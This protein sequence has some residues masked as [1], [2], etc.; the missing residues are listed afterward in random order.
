VNGRLFQLGDSGAPVN[1]LPRQPFALEKSLQTLMEEHL[2]TFLGV[3]FVQSEVSTGYLHAGRIDT[4]GLDENNFP[5]II[6]YKRSSN[7]NVITQGLY[8]L[9]WLVNSR[10]DFQRRVLQRLGQDVSE[11]VDWS[12]PRLICLAGEFSKFDQHAVQQIDRT[13]ELVKY[14]RFGETHLVLEPVNT[15]RSPKKTITKP[16]PP[17]GTTPEVTDDTDQGAPVSGSIENAETTLHKSSADLQALF[18]QLNE[19]LLGLGEDVQVKTTKL[20]FAYK[21]L[22]NFA[23]VVPGPTKGELWLYLHL[24]PAAVPFDALLMRD[25]TK[26]G[27]WGTGRLEIT[28]A[29]EGHLQQ[30]EPLLQQAYD[31]N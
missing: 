11:K 26:T 17:V 13:I 20:Y 16:L 22:R 12:G 9:D 15:P 14:V 6:E 25:V 10:Q 24:N 31:S 19:R 3:R 18:A 4:L 5:V 23:T 7:E 30:I 1:E 27:H 29:N 8:Y 21:K 28:L 2:E